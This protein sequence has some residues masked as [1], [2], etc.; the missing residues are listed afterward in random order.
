MSENTIEYRCTYCFATINA[1]TFSESMH[2]NVDR[3]NWIKNHKHKRPDG[4]ECDGKSFAEAWSPES[5]LIADGFV[6]KKE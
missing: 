1:P 5:Q 4:S 2:M 3:N 6:H